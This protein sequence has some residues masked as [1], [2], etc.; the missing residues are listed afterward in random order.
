MHD[1]VQ[2]RGEVESL[3]EPFV[4]GGCAAEIHEIVPGEPLGVE[5]LLLRNNS[6]GSYQLINRPPEGVAPNSAHLGGASA[7]L[8]H[9]VFSENARLTSDALGG[10]EDVYDWSGGVVRLV[11]I[12]PD[13]TPVAGSF[14]G[15]SADGSHIFFNANGKLYVRLNAERT[16]QI[17]ASQAGG[18]GGGGELVSASADG[19]KV[20]FLDGSSNGLTGDTVAGSGL[21]LYLYDFDTG[22]L[23]DLTP[24]GALEFQQ[25]LAVSQDTSR[26]YFLAGGQLTGSQT[27]ERGETAQA[28]Q[29]NIYLSHDGTTTFIATL[30]ESNRGSVVSPNGS[31]LA[32][33]S[34][35]SLTGYDNLSANR[36]PQPELF[37]YDAIA[38]MLL[39]AS[40]NP[41]GEAPSSEGT[42]FIG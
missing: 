2:S 30:E 28:G 29:P 14:A 13:G 8:S 19:S 38:Q 34:K 26:V 10:V 21:N 3:P 18:S 27:N 5:N 31:F 7:N 16:L 24:Y 1:G 4:G 6:D 9:V 40:C 32:F 42:S 36:E 35:R 41:S 17:D 39:C 12:L 23:T 33:V 20:F 25:V 15:I 22:R 37:L 11:A